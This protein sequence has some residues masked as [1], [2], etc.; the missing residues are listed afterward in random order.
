MRATQITGQA[1]DNRATNYGADFKLANTVYDLPS[2]PI[3]VAL[4]VEG[5]RESLEQSNSDFSSAVTR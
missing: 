4:G 5:R 3:A 2:G 1:N